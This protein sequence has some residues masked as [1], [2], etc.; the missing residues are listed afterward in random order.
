MKRKTIYDVAQEAGVSITTVSR[1]MNGTGYVSEDTRKRIEKAAENYRPVAVAR[2]M[3]MQKSK[4]IGIVINHD[5][6]YFFMNSTFINE[7]RAIALAAKKR[8]YKLLL[9][10]MDDE[11]EIKNLYFTRKVDGLIVMGCNRNS[12]IIPAMVEAKIPFVLIGNYEGE[13]QVSQVEVNDKRA[14]YDAMN[15]LIGLGHRKIGII[16]GALKYS[17]SFN[18]LEGYKEALTD[19]GIPI[20]NEFIEICENLTDVV[21][22]NLAKKLLYQKERITALM[23]FNDQI[24]VASYKA[25]KELGVRI[26]KDLSIVGFDDD[27][28]GKFVTPPLTTIWQ[29]SYEKGEKALNILIDALEEDRLPDK[30]EELNCVMI[31]RHSCS[32]V[33]E[34]GDSAQGEKF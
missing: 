21:V 30:K 2:E 15:Y 6:D 19:A 31:Y 17:S 7:L 23:M 26:G 24:A 25:A 32:A 14:V 5:A 11:E 12:E 34:N 18:R 28:V 16:T 9:E 27:R 20:R 3:K 1:A 8:R 33:N 10:L 22:E 13:E 29:P 4:T